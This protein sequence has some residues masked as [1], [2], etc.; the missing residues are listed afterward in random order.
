MKLTVVIPTKNEAANIASCVDAFAEFRN[1]IELI[2]VDNSSTDATRE[3]AAER[4]VKV[5]ERGP[6]RCAQ[7][8]C[9]WQS[10]QGEYVMFV[11]ADMIVPSATISEILATLD[12]ANAADAFYVPE[13]RGG[14]NSLRLRAR[15]F[16]RSF[17]N[18]TCIDGLRIIRRDRLAQ[19]GGY[20]ENLVACEDWDLD[21]RLLAAG[22]RVSITRGHLLHNEAKQDLKMF[23]KKKSYYATSI[24]RYR[25]KWNDDAVIRK[26]F[27]I[28]YRYFG[29]FLEQGKWRRA[30]RHPLLFTAMFCERIAVGIVYL[31]NR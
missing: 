23:L 14:G 7:R 8:N 9:G 16:E 31:L 15:N 30:L 20:D 25:R 21:R 24:D 5:L 10:A 13:I 4:G 11:D 3:I 27:G 22:A 26:Q 12:S 2:V 28:G 29:V 17:Y 19:V 6:E 1:R 18:A